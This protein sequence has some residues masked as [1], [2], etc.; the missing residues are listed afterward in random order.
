LYFDSDDATLVISL[1]ST[2]CNRCPQAMASLA[3]LSTRAPQ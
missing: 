2:I 3:T 1:V